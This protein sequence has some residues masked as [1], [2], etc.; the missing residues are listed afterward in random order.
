MEN[1]KKCSN[2][3]HLESIAIMFCPDCNLYLCSKC[4]NTHSDFFE[5]HQTYNLKKITQ[6]IFTGKC[7][8]LNHKLTLQFFCKDHNILCCAACLSKI[9]E[10][11]Y[12]QHFDC[13][14]CSIE[15][16]KEEKKNKLNENLIYLEEFSKTID[17]SIN[18]LKQIF[19]KINESKEELKTKISN[20]FTKIR[21]TLNERED[22]LFLQL[23][24]IYDKTYFKEDI[25]K[26][27][28]KSS[29][30]IKSYLD[31]GKL[32]NNGWEDNN[33]LI[34]NINDC[35]NIE[36]N[37][38]NINEIN[39]SLKKCSSE[40]INIKFI[41]NENDFKNFI[42]KIKIFGL[43]AEEKFVFKFIKGNNYTVNNNG[44][45]V[46]KNINGFNCVILGDR[47]IPKNKISKWK[48]KINTN[49]NDGYDDLF[50]GIGYNNSKNYK[51]C[52]SIFSR[53]SKIRIIIKGIISEYNNHKEK[54]K[55][56][57]IIEVIVDR[58]KGNLSFSIN[59][60]N[61]GIACSTIPKDDI[62]YPTVILYEKNQNIEL[63]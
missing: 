44:L 4:I 62:L 30:Q 51:D 60:V 32:L 10:K 21:N 46:T 1:S 42:E 53:S 3:K 35:I 6:E 40:K 18:E 63:I 15:K 20:I 2:A 34:S 61:F 13:N 11:E 19:E 14:V 37:I 25:I 8:K 48:I 50:F 41:V 36:N 17:N 47:E 49:I 16:I 9:K 33:K 23:D 59:D 58:I 28:E 45:N 39:E 38:K 24:N 31:K 22:E 56:G 12:G 52:W 55:Q 57:D 27:G 29:F 26:H 7:N 54:L 5:K 43:L